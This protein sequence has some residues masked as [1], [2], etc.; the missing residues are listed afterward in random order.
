MSGHIDGELIDRFIDAGYSK[1]AVIDTII[2]V[3]LR[4]VTNY[5]HAAL[6]EFA[7]DFP[8]APDLD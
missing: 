6:G 3:N 1:G 4:G 2:L 7:I 8:L 5:V